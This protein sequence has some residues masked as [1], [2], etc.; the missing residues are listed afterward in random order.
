[1]DIR[2]TDTHSLHRLTAAGGLVRG[3]RAIL[4]PAHPQPL[5]SQLGLT[6]ALEM[7]GDSAG[8]QAQLRLVRQAASK[9]V[10]RLTQT[11]GQPFAALLLNPLPT[12][13]WKRLAAPP[14]PPEDC[15]LTP[16]SGEKPMASTAWPAGKAVLGKG[17]GRSRLPAPGFV[18]PWDRG[19]VRQ[20]AGYVRRRVRWRT[21]SRSG[22]ADP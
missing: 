1:M 8:G 20:P 14:Q 22:S 21:A 10:G 11:F 3:Q 19:P 12:A 16:R 9:N 13:L 7:T 5:R 2:P 6:I 15:L 4:G 17:C 18:L